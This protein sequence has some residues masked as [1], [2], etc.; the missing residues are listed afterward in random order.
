MPNPNPRQTPALKAKQYKSLTKDF[1][2]L[3]T[4]SIS[5]KFPIDVEKTLL[6]LDSIER[7]GGVRE[8][9]VL[10]FRVITKTA[11]TIATEHGAMPDNIESLAVGDRFVVGDGS[12]WEVWE[13][14]DGDT[15]S[16]HASERLYRL[17]LL[18]NRSEE[19]E[20]E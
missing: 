20:G 11:N 4:K 8:A 10:R 13:E 1:G 2:K 12:V 5:F 15:S 16:G 18:G 7:T 3:G 17:L 9:V 6:E 19:T 14:K